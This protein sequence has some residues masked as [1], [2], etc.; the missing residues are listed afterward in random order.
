MLLIS[1]SGG[2]FPPLNVSNLLKGYTPHLFVVTSEWDTQARSRRDTREIR[3]RYA[4]EI[5]VRALAD[6]ALGPR[7]QA[8]SSAQRERHH[9]L[10]H[11]VR[12]NERNTKRNLN[13]ARAV[14][15]GGSV[16]LEL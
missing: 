6:R 4:R 14:G 11:L 10:P 1:H 5:R 9:H 2:T 8:W 12:R 13:W 16:L 3:A 15:V 7:R